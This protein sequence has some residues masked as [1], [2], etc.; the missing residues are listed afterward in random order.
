MKRKA[1]KQI[2]RMAGKLALAA[3]LLLGALTVCALAQGALDL[4]AGAG[5]LLGEALALNTVCGL[6]LPAPAPG[7][8]QMA[9]AARELSAAPRPLLRLVHGGGDRVA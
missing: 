2:K 5:L 9:A 6:L 1:Y 3:V 8:A 4:P 7:A